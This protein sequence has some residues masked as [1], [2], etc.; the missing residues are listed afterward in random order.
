MTE[1]IMQF[2]MRGLLDAAGWQIVIATVVTTHITIVSVT[3]F[4]HRAQAHRALEL[5]PIPSHF[6]RLW[7]WLMTGMTT[8]EWV[9]V[10]RKHHAKC[11]TREDPHSPQIHGIWTVLLEGVELYRAEAKKPETIW[12]HGRMTPDDWLERHVYSRHTR[13]GVGLVLVIDVLCFGAIGVTVWAVQMLWIPI[14]AAGVINGLG[15][16][17]GYR[18]IG[19]KDT[20]TNISPWGIVIGGEELHNNHHAYP[21]SARFSIQPWE[22]DLGWVYI[23][24]MEWCGL[25]RVKRERLAPVG[26]T[27]GVD[28]LN[29]D[30]V[31]GNF[32]DLHLLRETIELRLQSMHNRWYMRAPGARELLNLYIQQWERVW[33]E[34]QKSPDLARQL[35]IVWWL[36]ARESQLFGVRQL[37][38]ELATYRA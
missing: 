23:R 37:A 12:K 38:R 8:P 26:Q 34:A 11:E 28:T 32:S 14:M 2:L 9:A 20:S 25:A 30:C 33:Q 24:V 19:T 4:L 3:I 22:F 6:F 27:I 13:V 10:H 15:H 7:L 17:W 21:T 18:N 5:G 31:P 29:Y 16:Y 36:Q 1:M 35:L